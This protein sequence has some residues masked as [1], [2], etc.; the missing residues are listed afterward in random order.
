[1]PPTFGGA[2]RLGT[3]CLR[4]IADPVYLSRVWTDRLLLLRALPKGARQ[5][6]GPSGLTKGSA[7]WQA[8]T[9]WPGRR[10][11]EP[12]PRLCSTWRPP[13]SGGYQPW[14]HFH[15]LPWYAFESTPSVI[16]C[17]NEDSG[18]LNRLCP[19]GGQ[20]A[21]ARAAAGRATALEL[22]HRAGRSPIRGP[23][24]AS[25][26]TLAAAPPRSFSSAPLS[27]W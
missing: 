10:R 26:R 8:R 19:G 27:H 2:P 24:L 9:P 1:M 3:S 5:S 6:P 21:G 11:R 22:D 25:E 7:L 17:T 13:R 20:Q 14:R 15:S 18:L 16:L 4:R 23:S 12:R